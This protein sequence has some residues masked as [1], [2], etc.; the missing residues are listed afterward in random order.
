MALSWHRIPK[1]RIYCFDLFSN[2]VPSSR[3]LKWP[4][5]KYNQLPTT[6]PGFE[7]RISPV[8]FGIEPDMEDLALLND[9]SNQMS[10]HVISSKHKLRTGMVSSRKVRDGSDNDVE[11]TKPDVTPSKVKSPRQNTDAK[12][13]KLNTNPLCNT[14]LIDSKSFT[15]DVKSKLSSTTK[16]VKDIKLDSRPLSD[17]TNFVFA[18]PKVPDVNPRKRKLQPPSSDAK[19]P[20][21][22]TKTQCNANISNV[23]PTTPDANH[24]KQK[25][26]VPS[27]DKHKSQFVS[28][29][30]TRTDTNKSKRD[31]KKA[32]STKRNKFKPDSN[33]ECKIQIIKSQIAPETINVTMDDFDLDNTPRWAKNYMIRSFHYKNCF[34]DTYCD[35]EDFNASLHMY[36]D[37]NLEKHTLPINYA[38]VI[39]VFSNPKIYNPTSKFIFIFFYFYF[40]YILL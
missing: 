31:S 1:Q 37:Y 3:C 14:K 33:P 25:L 11:S 16:D 20:K 22:D 15:T 27:T 34:L 29:T 26:P 18:I 35:V 4:P 12:Q 10:S 9:H 7:G 28:R 2:K 36:P 24:C 21:L 17:A 30:A 19:K 13:T 8:L 6:E 5:V 23:K 38:G 32:S 39:A 40:L